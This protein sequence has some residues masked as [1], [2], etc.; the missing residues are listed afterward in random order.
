MMTM[1]ATEYELES[2]FV[3]MTV[4]LTTLLSPLT[5]TPLL[6]LLGA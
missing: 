2:T 3:T 6:A 5:I 4:M 1:I